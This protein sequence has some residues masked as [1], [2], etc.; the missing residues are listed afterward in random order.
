MNKSIEMFKDLY[1]S[2]LLS[3]SKEELIQMIA[4]YHNCYSKIGITCVEESKCNIKS[5][6]AVDK[7]R[8]YLNEVDFKFYDEEILR[9]KD[10]KYMNEYMKQYIQKR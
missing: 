5:D 2:T 3:L 10:K 8:N 4:M 1:G 7:I 6:E 9:K